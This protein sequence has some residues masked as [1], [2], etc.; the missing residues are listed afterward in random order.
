M[1]KTK[2][3]CDTTAHD[4]V[5]TSFSSEEGRKKIKPGDQ[6]EQNDVHNLKH[7]LAIGQKLC[8]PII[9]FAIF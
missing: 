1:T 9:P 2:R 5:I 6:H 3:W 7:E 4:V 8:L